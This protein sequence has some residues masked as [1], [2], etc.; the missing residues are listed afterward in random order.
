MP[1]GAGAWLRRRGFRRVDELGARRDRCT[2]G[3]LRITAV[4]AE[5][6]GHRWG[7]RLTHGPDTEAIG[8]LLEGGGEHGLRQPATPTST[9]RHAAA[10]PSAASTSRCCRC[11]AGARPRPRPPRPAERGRGGRRCSARG[12]PSPCTGAPSPCAGI[13]PR[14]PLGARMRR[15]LVEPPRRFAAAVAERALATTVLVT[16]PGSPVA[17]PIPA[18]GHGVLVSVLAAASDGLGGRLPGAVRRRAARLDRP[19]GP[20]RRGGRRGRRRSP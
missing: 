16:E 9:R 1:R 13:G 14:S 6:S 11:G 8:H 20:H 19:G 7:P 2:D 10:R 12:S 3:D 15:L 5:H 17:L 18:A 4:P